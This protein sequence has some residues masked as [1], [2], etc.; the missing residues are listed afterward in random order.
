MTIFRLQVAPTYL[1][2]MGVGNAKGAGIS[3]YRARMNQTVAR[4]KK[5]YQ[6][7][8]HFRVNQLLI[9]MGGDF[10]QPVIVG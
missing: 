8:L 9:G 1:L 2:R 7:H 3:C 4:W 10:D 5:T 6:L